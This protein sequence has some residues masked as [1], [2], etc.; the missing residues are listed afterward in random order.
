M[1]NTVPLIYSSALEKK[2]AQRVWFPEVL[3]AL[4]L[5]DFMQTVV[6]FPR[7]FKGIGSLLSILKIK[8]NETKQKQDKKSAKCELISL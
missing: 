5:F 3:R 2:P 4:D 1:L 7:M 6:K 8:R